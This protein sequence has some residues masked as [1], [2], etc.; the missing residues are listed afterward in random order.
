MRQ[1]K[2]DVIFYFFVP[3]FSIATCLSAG[4]LYF[5]GVAHLHTEFVMSFLKL[6][7]VPQIYNNTT[8]FNT[9]MF[10]TFDL[11]KFSGSNQ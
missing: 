9:I 10:T 5:S 3:N 11:W 7:L 6:R 2:Q 4:R 8:R 1:R